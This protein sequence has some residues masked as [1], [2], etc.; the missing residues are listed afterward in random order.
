MDDLARPD[1]MTTHP[2]ITHPRPPPLSLPSA[3]AAKPLQPC[4]V[5][6]L[7]IARICAYIHAVIS[8]CHMQAT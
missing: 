2:H 7:R 6:S 1:C 3:L 4:A 8:L 5:S